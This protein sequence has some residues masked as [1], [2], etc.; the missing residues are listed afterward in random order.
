[1]T[2]R[3]ELLGGM[4]QVYRRPSSPYW[5][6]S[7]S[8][9]GRQFRAS[10]KQDG[11]SLAKDFAEDWFLSLRGKDKWG[12][13]LAKVKTFRKAAAK[14]ID[15]Y[16]VLTGGERSERCPSRLVLSGGVSVA[17]SRDAPSREKPSPYE[18]EVGV[19]AAPR[20]RAVHGEHRAPAR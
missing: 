11:L 10:T 9:G 3:H 14:F 2:N 12:G 8:I 17:L 6:C 20:L 7:A 13:G 1:M 19:R 15:E 18:M 16:E 4:V 5:Q